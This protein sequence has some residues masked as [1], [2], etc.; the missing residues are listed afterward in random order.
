M[1]EST[2]LVIH[3]EVLIGD[4]VSHILE[5]NSRPSV[6]YFKFSMSF[7]ELLIISIHLVKDPV[8]SIN[9][10]ILPN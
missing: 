4:T 7:I 5:F 10:L 9:M 2:E 8:Q 1:T 6:P 3:L